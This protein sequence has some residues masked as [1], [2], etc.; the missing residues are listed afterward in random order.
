MYEA[1]YT[2]ELKKRS[3][4]REKGDEEGRNIEEPEDKQHKTEL[5]T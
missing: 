2:A 5:F 1:R 4:K 3:I